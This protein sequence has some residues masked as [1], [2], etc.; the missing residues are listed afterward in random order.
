[1]LHGIDGHLE[2]GQMLAVIGPSGSGKTCLL[3]ILAERKTIGKISGL[4]LLDGQVRACVGWVGGW[5]GRRGGGMGHNE[6]SNRTHK[7][8][9]PEPP[10]LQVASRRRFQRVTAYVTQED[11]FH[12][13]STVKE[14][15]LFQA[16]L[17][18]ARGARLFTLD[19]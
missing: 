8:I 15:V 11:I 18:Y 5:I 7:P 16:N 19:R 10:A 6:S 3:D 9:D 17:R 4:R 1:V 14:A 2:T 13:T 12:P